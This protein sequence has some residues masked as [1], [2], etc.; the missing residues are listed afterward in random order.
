[1]K[2]PRLP[3]M[4]QVGKFMGV[5]TANKTVLIAIAV[6]AMIAVPATLYVR[7][8]Q[9]NKQTLEREPTSQETLNQ[10]TTGQPLIASTTS[11]VPSNTSSKP[12]TNTYKSPTCTDTAIPYKTIYEENELTYIGETRASGGVDGIAHTCS[13]GKH[14]YTLPPFNKTVYVGTRIQVSTLPEPE[15]PWGATPEEIRADK[16]Y[17]C[18]RYVKSISNSSAYLQCYNI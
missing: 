7:E 13:D 6:G 12:T 18:I 9:K 14:N 10:S 17:A 11:T 4:P 5:V 1:M 3:K 2:I 16:I 8:A 15:A